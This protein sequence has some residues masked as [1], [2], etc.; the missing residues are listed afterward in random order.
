[1]SISDQKFAIVDIETTGGRAS[2]D[3]VTEIGIVL[4][5]G[6]QIISTYDT[7]INPQTY[8][9]YGI[10][11][12]TGITQEM[13]A[14]APLFHEVARQIVEMT[15]DAIFVAHNVRFDYGFLREEFA[16]L[17]YTFTRKQLCTV[18]MSRKAFPGLPSYSLE[19]LIRHFAIQT[20]A[21][22][23]AL[24]DAMATANILERILLQEQNHEQIRTMVNMGIQETRLPFGIQLDQLHGLPESCGVYY[25]HDQ[26]GQVI[27]V[28]KSINIKKRIA[29]HFA[30]TTDKGRSLHQQVADVSYEVTG[31]ELVAL[32]LE[33]HEI[34]RLKPPIN[35][36]QRKTSF[37]FAIHTYTNN[38]GFIC[39]DVIRNSHEL[40]D[41]HDVISEYPTMSGAKGRINFVL[42]ELELCARFCHIFPGNGACFNY[43]IK[44]CRGGCAGQESVEDYNARAT[45]AAERLRTVF[46]TDFLLLD[47]GRSE[48]ESA[49]IRIQ[50]GYFTGFGYVSK[51]T[52]AT[53]T[54]LN[55][56]VKTYP[57]YPD[58]ARMIQRFMSENG[59]VK[60]IRL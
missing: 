30:D 7:L 34:K 18:R 32:L 27:Y 39:F 53:K 25:L 29:E 17:G 5:D 48:D 15:Q 33:A 24:A 60:K 20:P 57:P 49:V 50:N 46:D 31:S 59:G 26:S 2:R 40:R 10:T 4:H 58:T 36:A 21:R 19:N 38:E 12:L 13:V 8:I 11:R 22:H 47:V 56:A 9:P 51:D 23:R 28:G 41:K 45:Q 42:R 16:R 14:D 37:P 43:H 44:Q 3:K 52:P 35:R 1:M 55:D 54:T 6:R